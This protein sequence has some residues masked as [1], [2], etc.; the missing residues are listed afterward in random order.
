[1]LVHPA[2]DF[3]IKMKTISAFYVLF[4]G[5]LFSAA[6][7][8]VSRTLS[9]IANGGSH[10][11]AAKIEAARSAGFTFSGWELDDVPPQASLNSGD[12][13]F[14]SRAIQVLKGRTSTHGTVCR[15]EVQYAHQRSGYP[16][17]A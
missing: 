5:T 16:P 6:D 14:S 4:F 17:V 11:K 12:T 13:T 1:M 15:G 8:A 2:S 10:T 9:D 7:G 3:L